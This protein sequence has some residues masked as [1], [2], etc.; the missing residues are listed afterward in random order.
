MT[1]AGN[2]ANPGS[3]SG[4]DRAAELAGAAAHEAVQELAGKA[5]G[6]MPGQGTLTF[7]GPVA[8]AFYLDDA[9]VVG[10][11]GPVGSGKTTT[12]IHSRVR[13]A[14]M[15]PISS[16][17]RTW[18]RYRLGVTRQTYR[19]LWATTIPSYIDVIPKE[20]GVWAGGRGDPA[21]HVIEFEDHLG[22]IRF[23]TEFRAFGDDPDAAM[24]GWQ[25]TDLWMNETD[26]LPADV[27]T[28]G[29]GR[30][31]RY[32]GADHYRAYP[33]DVADYGQVVCDFNAPDEDNWAYD[34]FHDQDKRARMAAEL[35]RELPPGA[36]PVEISFHEQPGGREPGAENMANLPATYYQTQVATM[37]LAGQSH[38]VARLVDNKVGFTRLGDPVFRKEFNPRVH[39]AAATLDP[40][41]D[42]PLKIGL[43][44]GFRA[45]AVIAQNPGPLRWRF[46]AE[47]MRP[48]ERLLA[49]QFAELLCELL[50]TPRFAG[51]RVEGAW[52]DLAGEAG[53]SLAED[54][55]D[56]WNRQISR[57][58]GFPVRPQKVGANRIAPRL[59]AIRAPLDHIH[60]GEP[61]VLICP[62][63]ATRFLRAGFAA[64]YVWTDEI[65]ANGDKR[66][67][68]DKSQPEANVMD[69][70]GY[71]LLSEHKRPG[72]PPSPKEARARSDR[73]GGRPKGLQTGWA[74][75]QPY[76]GTA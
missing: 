24:R 72:V 52:G 42:L 34:V 62:S 59:E 15:A 19:E 10:I 46:M 45:A 39:I 20:L 51:L 7:P 13:R 63:P 30:V 74:A 71:L 1:G 67:V 6:D 73:P 48:D 17:D 36:R 60:Q 54:D 3:G 58:C 66:K 9:S 69:A 27:L 16:I 38:K 75:A 21:L 64:R 56:N 49:R 33:V 32:P 8:Q 22:P 26:T 40:D 70:T 11:Q 50:E 18:R 4:V 61:G 55:L 37:T 47:L 2:R 68:P 31:K 57:A 76:G 28:T 43:D 35:N 14:R 23:E 29:M 12:L 44:Q 65:G 41:P 5:T 25:I 53:S